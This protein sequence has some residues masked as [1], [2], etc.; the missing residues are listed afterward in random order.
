MFFAALIVFVTCWATVSSTVLH[1]QRELRMTARNPVPVTEAE[2]GSAAAR[3]WERPDTLDGRGISVVF[4]QPLRQDAPPPPGL[5]RWPQPGEA[6]LSPAL[7]A[8][9][10][11]MADRYGKFAGTIAHEGLA[12]GAELVVYT[13]PARPGFFDEVDERTSYI[14][15]F[16]NP[17]RVFFF[18]SSHQFDRGVGELLLLLL[19]MAGLPCAA[20]VLVAV[21]SQSESRDQR[22]SVLDAL[23]A[24]TRLRALVLAGEAALPLA[25][26]VGVGTGLAAAVSFT[27]PELPFTGYR[28]WSEDLRAALPELPLLAVG[29]LAVLLALVVAAGIRRPVRTGTRPTRVPP[30]PA[31]WA[32]LVFAAGLA[33]AVWGSSHRGVDGRAAF[34][35]GAAITLVSLPH[36][37][38]Q[39]A[40]RLGRRLADRGA[41]KGDAGR[42]IAGRWLAA[43]PA[44]LARLSAALLVGLGIVTIGQVLTTQFTG[45]AEQARQRYE[46]S[47]ASLVQIRSRNIP[48]TADGFIAAVGPSRTL[49]Y[50]PQRESTQ[51]MPEVALTA[52]CAALAELGRLRSCPAQPVRPEEAFEALTPL[53]RQVFLGDEMV[54]APVTTVCGCTST[55]TGGDLALYGF[56]VLNHEGEAGVPAIEQAAYTHL[57]GPMTYRPGQSWFL[58]TAAQAA[59]IRWLLDV[60]LLGLLALALAGSL[61]AAGIFLEQARALGPLASFRAD[62]RFYRG[63]AFWNLALPLSVVG[64]AGTLVAALLGRLLINLGKGGTMSLPILFL[65]LAVVA[66]SGA[67]VALTCG[68]VAARQAATWRPRAD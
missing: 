32:P 21:R 5:P 10:G 11:A 63:I 25:A 36:T 14:S 23:G 4:V 42:L 50:A 51:D 15:R 20:L 40:R 7:L 28:V 13:T 6:Y 34:V 22:L 44:T 19:L 29:V 31:R 8:A 45:P 48:A 1:E 52:Q 17:D 18:I 24:P 61:G 57:I 56:L 62:T 60:A 54:S 64:V 27:S 47:G 26:G 58:G 41:S 37:A 38:S 2:R 33:V 65:G 67:V 68:K 16:G 3:W 9:D 53:G 35:I 30:K 12:D 43:R 49:L 59:Q 66:A 46:Q 39:V 55:A